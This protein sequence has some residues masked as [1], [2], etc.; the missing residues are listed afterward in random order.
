MRN[1]SALLAVYVYRCRVWC[2]Q[3]NTT[4]YYTTHTLHNTTQ[5]NTV[6]NSSDMTKYIYTSSA[7]SRNSW[8]RLRYLAEYNHEHEKRTPNNS[9]TVGSFKKNL[10]TTICVIMK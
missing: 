1:T 8:L 6:R 5:Y 2:E 10:P 3:H 7:S 4:Q 9:T